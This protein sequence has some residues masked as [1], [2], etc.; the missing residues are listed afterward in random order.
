M[1]NFLFMLVAM[2]ILAAIFTIVGANAFNVPEPVRYE[3]Y[4]VKSGDT[5]WGIAHQSDGWNK[6]DAYYIIND[7]QERSNCTTTI[8]PGDVIYVPMYEN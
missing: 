5:L 2:I 4:I 6:M 1:K 7:M 3:T 8:Y